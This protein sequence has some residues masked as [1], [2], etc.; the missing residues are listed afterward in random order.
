MQRVLFA[1]GL[2]LIANAL[3]LL[4]FAYRWSVEEPG[5]DADLGLGFSW[6]GS[7]VLASFLAAPCAFPY[8]LW[9]NLSSWWAPALA[10]I[11]I[12]LLIA[13][14]GAALFQVALVA[15]T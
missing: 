12:A 2:A 8:Q 14:A 15:L 9:L 3:L 1:F 4:A 6:V 11:G 13:A 10:Y 7:A 5:P